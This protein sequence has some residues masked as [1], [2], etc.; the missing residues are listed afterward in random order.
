MEDIT[1]KLA[2][3]NIG[4]QKVLYYSITF[5]Y[6]D[7][8]NLVRETLFNTK[9][10]DDISETYTKTSDSFDLF[11][12]KVSDDSKLHIMN[13]YSAHIEKFKPGEKFIIY[14]NTLYSANSEFHITTLFTGGKVHEKSTDMES[15]LGHK[16]LVK[17]NK[18]GVSGNFITI[19]IESIKLEDGADIFYYG[20]E[21]KHITIA[22]NK[23]EKKVFPKDSYTALSNGKIYELEHIIEG[24]TS[25]VIQ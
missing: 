23:T 19:G 25:K 3:F 8:M 2:T 10:T 21:V 16:V 6:T 22:L 14:N 9:I 13:K 17:I 4:K 20:N 12:G 11:D 24:V 5:N 15:Q 7:I 1:N 18:F